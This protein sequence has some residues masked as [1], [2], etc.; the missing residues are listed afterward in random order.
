VPCSCAA[1]ISA[2]SALPLVSRSA[3][4]PRNVGGPGV[5]SRSPPRRT[6][7]LA[8]SVTGSFAAIAAC[9]RR[10]AAI[11]DTTTPAITTRAEPRATIDSVFWST[12]PA[13]DDADERQQ[14]EDQVAREEHDAEDPQRRVARP[15]GV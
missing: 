2:A 15:A 11:D 12:S 8:G 10:C 6:W 3:T 7:R 4:A 5:R 1:R 13:A 9:A 14:R